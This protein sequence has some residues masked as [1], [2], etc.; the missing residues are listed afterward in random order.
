MYHICQ[1]IFK[2]SPIT[3]KKSGQGF[4]GSAI[5]LDGLT[6]MTNFFLIHLLANFQMIEL[7]IHGGVVRI[8]V[9]PKSKIDILTTLLDAEQNDPV[10]KQ[11]IRTDD[12][13]GGGGVTQLLLQHA[14]WVN[15]ILSA[16]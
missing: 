5:W 4:R 9:S 2:K 7:F 15:I 3:I 13:H 10:A 14:H 11:E 6:I 16:W 12:E 8:P 1:Q